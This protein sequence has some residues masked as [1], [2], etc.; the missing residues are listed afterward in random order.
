MHDD[1]QALHNFAMEGM[2]FKAEDDFVKMVRGLLVSFQCYAF[3]LGQASVAPMPSDVV[4]SRQIVDVLATRSQG[5]SVFCK[6]FHRYYHLKLVRSRVC[7]AERCS[8]QG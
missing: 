3:D 4:E 1:L 8:W 7:Q 5:A 2:Q 6:A